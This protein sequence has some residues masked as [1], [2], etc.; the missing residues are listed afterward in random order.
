MFPLQIWVVLHLG[1]KYSEIRHHVSLFFHWCKWKSITLCFR[2]GFNCIFSD[3]RKD[4]TVCSL[5]SFHW[6]ILYYPFADVIFIYYDE[7]FL[8]WQ[9]SES[10]FV[11][12]LL[13][14]VLLLRPL[15]ITYN[16]QWLLNTDT[17]VYTHI[18]THIT[19]WVCFLWALFI[20]FWGWLLCTRQ[21]IRE[22]TT[23]KC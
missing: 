4:T 3:I 18:F 14:C 8:M 9:N 22:P 6:K 13:A 7:A 23:I 20:P 12:F 19:C 15:I 5:G 17:V 1:H 10:C 16:D 2:W 21:T 11:S